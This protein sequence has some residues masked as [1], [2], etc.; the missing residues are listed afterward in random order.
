MVLSLRFPTKTHNTPLV[1]KYELNIIS[2]SGYS[3][4][5]GGYA[6]GC[7][8]SVRPCLLLHPSIGSEKALLLPLYL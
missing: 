3:R 4:H 7:Y 1:N 5:H 6:D 8:V 2:N